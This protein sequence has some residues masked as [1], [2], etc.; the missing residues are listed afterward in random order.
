MIVTFTF[1]EDIRL[2]EDN[3]KWFISYMYGWITTSYNIQM[4]Y[5]PMYHTYVYENK[6][7]KYNLS[8]I[9]WL[10]LH[11]KINKQVL[12]STNKY[13]FGVV[14][15]YSLILKIRPF[16]T[17]QC[18]LTPPS[19]PLT[20][21]QHKPTQCIFWTSIDKRHLSHTILA[22]L[23]YVYARYKIR[24]EKPN[25]PDQTNPKSNAN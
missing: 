5:V 9:F 4:Y 17:I 18:S 10:L 22:Q 1:T 15:L 2:T 3:I 11:H 13:I 23:M 24:N 12:R 25:F 21:K 14:F 7:T 16:F 19:L 20:H 8:F 6:I